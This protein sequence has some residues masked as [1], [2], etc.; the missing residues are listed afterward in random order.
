MEM[1]SLNISLPVE[2]KRFIE[3][4]TSSGGYGT[5]S[6]Y[7]RELV[8]ADQKQEADLKAAEEKVVAMLLEGVRSLERGEGIEVTP[9]YWEGKK[10]ELFERFGKKDRA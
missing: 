8:R 1:T 9:E 10:R 7:I 6:E 4:K 5:V 2:M 3:D